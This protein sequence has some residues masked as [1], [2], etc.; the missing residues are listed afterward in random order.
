MRAIL[1]AVPDALED[2]RL[3]RSELARQV[4]RISGQPH[5]E[6]VLT[7]SWGAVLKP[8]AFEGLLCFGPNEGR[9]VTFVS[10][11][12][13]L[14]DWQEV[15]TEPALAEVARRYLDAYGPATRED[16]ARWFAMDPRPAR[17][18]FDR[19]ADDLVEVDVEGQRGWLTPSSAE[20]LAEAA[21]TEVVRLL[22]GFDP[23]VVGVLG[24]LDQLLPGPF[25]DR[26]SRTSGWISPVLMV[27]G[28]LAGTWRHELRRERVDIRIEP[29]TRQSR[30]I[31]AA[32]EDHAEVLG[33]L[34]GHPVEV[35]WEEPR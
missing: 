8:A 33:A 1:H 17:E 10:P 5:L 3:T 12:R 11:R 23:Y 30:R 4:A 34:L 15:A 27:D 28:R 18:L 35:A 26:V 21:E 7:E 6:E 31:R 25:R 22:A 29:F 13:W 14:G 24:R 9:T 16:F 19:L 32:A 20:G 2:R